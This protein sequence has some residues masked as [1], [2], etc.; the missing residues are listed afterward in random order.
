MRRRR[1]FD[2][3]NMYR[4]LLNTYFN[5]RTVYFNAEQGPIIKS[6]NYI[7]IEH[8]QEKRQKLYPDRALSGKAPKTISRSGTFG[9]SAENY[10]PIGPS[11]VT[12]TISRSGPL[13]GPKLKA[14]P[15]G[16]LKLKA[17]PFEGPR[18]D[19]GG[20]GGTGQFARPLTLGPVGTIN[21]VGIL[22]VLY[23][24]LKNFWATLSPTP[25]P[26]G[27][28][29]SPEGSATPPSTI[30]NGFRPEALARVQ[31]A[32][33]AKSEL[34]STELCSY[35]NQNY[36]IRTGISQASSLVIRYKDHSEVLTNV[37]M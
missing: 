13:G 4:T 22:R 17:N 18:P 14:N 1:D 8:F 12:K 19:F 35:K 11:G 3:L 5:F 9:K 2:L 26:T 31:G 7:P 27:Y 23:N 28:K 21:S 32:L 30:F 24:P 25:L 10:I 33:S 37:V 6:Q 20:G 34:A 16:G 36:I 29:P 15:F